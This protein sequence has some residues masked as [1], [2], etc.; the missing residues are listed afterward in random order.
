MNLV[1]VD[2]EETAAQEAAVLE[3][4][5]EEVLVADLEEALEEILTAVQEKCTKQRVL[6]A[7]KN[8]KFPSNQLKT[9][10]YIAKTV[11][12]RRK[13]FSKS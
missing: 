5:D 8:A 6:N 13:A 11:I 4:E 10:Q 7:E 12:R 1:P 9:S 2:P 3:A